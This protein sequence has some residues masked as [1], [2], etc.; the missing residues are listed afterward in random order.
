[1]VFIRNFTVIITAAFLLSHDETNPEHIFPK[2][3][4]AF[5]HALI[6]QLPSY[7]V[8]ESFTPGA[9][10]IYMMAQSDIY[11]NM[12]IREDVVF[13]DGKLRVKAREKLSSSED[14]SQ[15]LKFFKRKTK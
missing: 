6:L 5:S 13:V 14:V 8:T 3:S 11:K 15:K 12:G 1:M 2:T 4:H 10:E 9:K 7:T